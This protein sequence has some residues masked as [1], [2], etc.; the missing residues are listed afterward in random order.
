MTTTYRHQVAEEIDRIPAEYLP[1]ILEVIRAFRE[2][3]TFK[4]AE[5]SFR[6]GWQEA[7]D[8]DTHPA[9]ELWADIDA[10]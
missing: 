2:S 3:V 6:H 8:G 10:E 5:A 9:S 4:S 7:Q 1:T